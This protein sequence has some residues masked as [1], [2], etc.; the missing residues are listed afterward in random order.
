MPTKTLRFP[1]AFG[2]ED[3]DLIENAL[4]QMAG[5]RDVTMERPMK[6]ATIQWDAPTSW[7]EVERTVRD[8]G[9]VP[10]VQA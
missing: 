3:L 2:D 8:L 7:D 1:S 5:M 6:A 9:Y 4:R 10:E